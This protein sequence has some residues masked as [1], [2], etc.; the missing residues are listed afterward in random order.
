MET[1]LRN[2]C[3]AIKAQVE[4][5]VL[6][7][8][9]APTT[10]REIVEGVDVT[11]AASWGMA[12]STSLCPTF[13]K[14]MKSFDADMVHLHEPNPLAV[15]SYLRI[16]PRG[17]L[18]ISFHSEVVRQQVLGK[19]YR[20]YLARIL[21]RADRIVVGSPAPMEHWTTLAPVREKCAV[22]PFGID[23][24]PFQDIERCADAVKEIRHRFGEPLILF[25]GRLVYYKGLEYLIDAMREV[26]ARLL[27]IGDGPL[28]S[29]LTQAIQTNGLRNKVVLLGERSQE[30][31]MAYYH[32]CDLFVLPSIHK[33]E[34]FGIVQ[35]EAMACG[36]PV[37]STD[38]PSGVP[39]VNQN[40]QTGL[41]IPPKDVGAMIR[42]INLLLNNPSLSLQLGEG[43]R[44]R[45]EREFTRER[46][47]ARMLALYE[48]VLRE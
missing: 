45:V 44:Q 13:P 21:H 10:I 6:V 31:L 36:K 29:K 15:L 14:L 46:M 19:L 25:V 4:L 43:G 17:K 40:G 1:V 26:S 5:R 23:V 24:R 2:L 8:H 35:L 42:A 47:G 7:A 39:W 12:A 20:P 28:K 9:T 32:A 34:A 38:L 33:S 41:V 27:I 18:I 37:I 3:Q 30:Q 11:R 48:Q 22:V 16:K